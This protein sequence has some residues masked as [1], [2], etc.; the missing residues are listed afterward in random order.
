MPV[1]TQI[2]S[3]D[4]VADPAAAV[5]ICTCECL[6]DENTMLIDS[7]EGTNTL[8]T[9]GQSGLFVYIDGVRHWATCA[10]NAA[11]NSHANLSDRKMALLK[12]QQQ[13]KSI[14]GLA[15]LR[16]PPVPATPQRYDPF[17]PA[18]LRP[19]KTSHLY[20][21]SRFRGKQKSG[22]SSYDVMVDIK[23]VN[24]ADSSLCGY[25][26]INGLT[27]EYPELTT[28]F[29]A[30]IIGDAHPFVTKKWEADAKTDK[31]H[32]MMFKP[33]HPMSDSFT[34][35]KFKYDFQNQD[36]IF[37]RWKEHFLVPDH[38]VEG[39]TGASFAG[40][41]YICYNKVTGEIDGYYFHRSSE[42]FQNLM[43]THIQDQPI[44]FGSYEF[45]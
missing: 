38:H 13:Q 5:T 40:F 30:E 34:Q 26:H 27:E 15:L 14:G 20:A 16:K 23:D 6:P 7:S 36:V 19:T 41:Y 17:S 12:Q 9:N 22:S 8:G 1:F 37:M 45:R 18:R 31:E 10:L 24:L 25:L 39:I 33:F 44:S 2:C 32:W 3:P 29:D 35:E 21:G 4:P 11:T 28:F 42:K 43:L